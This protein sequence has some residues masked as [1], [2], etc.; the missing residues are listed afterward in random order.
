MILA[1]LHP[2]PI[3][4]SNLTA[5]GLANR[6]FTHQIVATMSPT[7][8]SADGQLPPGVGFNTTTGRF[9]GFATT[10]G[11]YPIQITATNADGFDTETL[12]INIDDLSTTVDEPSVPIGSNPPINWFTQTEVTHDGVSA[13]QAG[14]ID[15]GEMSW[16]EM[17]LSGPD[18]ISFFWKVESENNFDYLRFRDDGSLAQSISGI[19]D[20][21]EIV[22]DIPAGNHVLRWEYFKDGSVSIG[23][24][25]GW[26]DE[27]FIDSLHPEPRITGVLRVNGAVDDPFSYQIVASRNPTSYSSS[28]LPPG[29]T[30]NISTG[31]ISGMPT[32]VGEYPVTVTAAN[33]SGSDTEDLLIVLMHTAQ[34]PFMETFE[35]GTTFQPF[36][37]VTG[38][39]AAR[40]LVTSDH[41]PNNGTRHATMDTTV[42]TVDARNEL[43][44]ALDLEG[45]SRVVLRFW[46][47]DMGNE[48]D[49]PPPMPFSDG[50]DF[51][52]VAISEDGVNWYE[53]QPLR[54]EIDGTYSQFIVDLDD[55]IALHGLEFNS[56]FQIRFNY[57][58]NFTMPNGGFAFDDISVG[59]F[60]SEIAVEDPQGND[61]DDG[62]SSPNLV[63]TNTGASSN[64]VFTVLNVGTE[65]LTGLA[66]SIVGTNSGDF[67]AVLGATTLNPGETTTA[68]VTFAPGA[69]GTRNSTLRIA[70]NDADENPFDIGLSGTGT[71]S[72]IV[73]EFPIGTG[74]V[75]GA[76]TIDFGSKAVGSTTTHLF[77]IRNT[78]STNLDGVEL[79]LVGA[80]ADQFVIEIPPPATLIPDQTSSFQ[81]SF[82]PI[83][84]GV[85]SVELQIESNDT[86]ESP[87]DISLAGTA[88]WPE[89]VVE[90]EGSEISNGDE[91]FF[92]DLIGSSSGNQTVSG[93][94]RNT[95]SVPLLGI[96]SS[97]DGPDANQFNAPGLLNATIEGGESRP[98]TLLFVPS[99]NGNR[100][101]T[102]HIANNDEDEAPFDIIV[103]AARLHATTLDTFADG[104]SLTGE[105]RLP[106]A[107]GDG[108]TSTLLEEYAFNLDPT[109]NDRSIMEAGGLSGLPLIRIVGDRLQVEYL[110]RRG[111]PDLTYSVEFSS[112]MS[113]TPPDGFKVATEPETISYVSDN[114]FRVIVRDTVTI[115][116]EPRRFGRVKVS[117]PSA[118]E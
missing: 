109:A 26:V 17:T 71:D 33:A 68:T 13:A 61:L 11:I 9:L 60:G 63:T 93:V 16:M 74:L 116:G 67:S 10:A 24:D 25:T 96:T 90:I 22:Y 117:Y 19:A 50:A 31:E 8:Y 94:I 99:A 73:I 2:E 57:F 79:S 78:G 38:T 45:K 72:D 115:D 107:D 52:G 97:I 3:I 14:D 51:D 77:R 20:W 92:D 88:A 101:A 36:W 37:Q 98:F 65:P 54:N 48:I 34:Y 44:L 87:F 39:G 89:I 56:T 41:A 32:T 111:D 53:V 95:G 58:D 100:T 23:A 114:Y 69:L 7:S 4:T 118:G 18:T 49:G 35:G 21:H 82:S 62:I 27:V 12:V 15:D 102:I 42:N 43:T 55:A 80:D 5:N 28:A 47:K 84:A 104:H 30:L 113:E 64:H 86:D 103:Y 83:N 76:S 59:D 91:V 40:T 6:A 66:A 108:D 112:D 105:L 70:S 1:A 75:D 81:V 46:A 106:G 29:L 110:R 85:F